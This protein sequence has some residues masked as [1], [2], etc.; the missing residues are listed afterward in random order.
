M[1]TKIGLIIFFGILLS[2]KILQAQ[3]SGHQHLF[4]LM[5]YVGYSSTNAQGTSNGNAAV[6]SAEGGYLVDVSQANINNQQAYS[7]QL[8]NHLKKVDTFF[9]ARQSSRSL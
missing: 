6:I 9:E 7:L 8:D 2:T 4:G 3:D 5:P 1:Q